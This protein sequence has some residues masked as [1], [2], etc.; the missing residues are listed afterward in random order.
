VPHFRPFALI[1]LLALLWSLNG[2]LSFVPEVSLYR[3]L[4]PCS[5]AVLIQL[6]QCGEVTLH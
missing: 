1:N 3:L 2:N 4:V 5:V 6:M